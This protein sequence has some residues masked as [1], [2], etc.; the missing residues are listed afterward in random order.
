MH[1]GRLIIIESRLIFVVAHHY[2]LQ[3]DLTVICLCTACN[4]VSSL[5]A[6]D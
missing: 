6:I 1:L 2:F 3:Y 4:V 5:S